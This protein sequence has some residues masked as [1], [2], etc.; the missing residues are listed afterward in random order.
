MQAPI[1]NPPITPQDTHNQLLV[2]HVHPPHWK[3]PE[4][5]PSYHLVVIG[6]GTAGLVTAAGAA[7]LGAKVALIERHFMGGDCL[8]VGCVPSKTFLRSSRVIGELRDA[9]RFGITAP[10]DVLIDFGAVMER[11]R[12]V[13]AGLSHHDSA[14]RF[15]ELGIDVF[16]GNARFSGPNQ[17][18]VGDRTLPFQRA[19][20]ATGA[21]AVAPSIPGLRE[22]GFLTN[23]TVFN[24]T[25]RPT[26]LAVIGAGPIGCEL[27]QAFQRLGS[28][29][30]LFHNKGHILDREDA[31]AA[32]IVE[33]S[34]QHDGVRLV[35]NATIKRVEKAGS[36]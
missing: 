18:N 29:V 20:I 23:E 34:L 26:R 16:L 3:N 19:V 32:A 8:N 13:R 17:I 35:L 15:S 27:A 6:A 11:V 25:E 7:G 22:T 30:S 2:S 21:R 28:Q 24:L 36:Q 10:S 12:K 33:K 5:A 14:K 1:V 4:P 31:E 9:T